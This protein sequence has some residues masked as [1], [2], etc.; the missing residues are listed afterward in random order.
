MAGT[1]GLK[2]KLLPVVLLASLNQFDG[3]GN[4]LEPTYH[5]GSNLWQ[6]ESCLR[7]EQYVKTGRPYCWGT[8]GKPHRRS[9][10]RKVR[11][12]EHRQPDAGEYFGSLPG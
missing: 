5:A 4:D 9:S 10:T 6:C 11:P 12:R 3:F 1:S 2:W 7:V 8:P